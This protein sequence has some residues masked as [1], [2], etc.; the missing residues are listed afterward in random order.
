MASLTQFGA[1]VV[2]ASGLGSDGTAD[3]SVIAPSLQS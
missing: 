3:W 1:L 2:V